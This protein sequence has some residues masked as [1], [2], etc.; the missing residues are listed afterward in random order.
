MRVLLGNKIGRV[1][2]IALAIA[3]IAIMAYLV[4]LH[5]SP[6]D[7]AFC[8]LSEKLSC[9]IVNKSIYSAVLG[10]PV[11]IMGLFYFIAV[12]GALIRK[13]TDN[14]L[15]GIAFISIVFLGP[16]LYF[17]ATEIFFIKSICVFCEASK[18]VI[19]SIAFISWFLVR[20]K[21]FNFQ[22]VIAGIVIG[23]VMGGA[24]FLIHASAG[25]GEEHNEFAQC[26]VDKGF[27]MYGSVTCQFCA[28]QRGMFGDA[29][30]FIDEIECDPRNPYN[31]AELCIEKN[32]E[33]TPTWIQEDQDG[34]ELFRF[35]PG[36]IKLEKLS[37]VSG[38][39]LT[40]EENL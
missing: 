7:S 4:Y 15:K 16:S 13:Y 8:D 40:H 36:V 29:F 19:F 5:Y 1:L 33:H 24:T 23:A 34:N 27:K 11:S 14:T 37:E 28:K 39:P 26:I 9:S 6:E 30:E 35:D 12:L 38:C 18:V 25:P 31:V 20:K 2:L 32:I 10:I 21:G 22:Y 3:G 17:T